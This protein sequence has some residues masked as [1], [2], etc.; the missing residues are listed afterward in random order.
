VTADEWAVSTDAVGMLEFLGTAAHGRKGRL[1]ATAAV[2]R[3]W[4]LFPHPALRAGVETAERH[5]EGLASDKELREAAA[6]AWEVDTEPPDGESRWQAVRRDL[7]ETAAAASAEEARLLVWVPRWVI[8]AA[9]VDGAGPDDFHRPGVWT[10]GDDWDTR[11]DRLAAAVP[12]AAAARDR[13]RQALADLLR[14]IF[15]NPYPP[16]PF[17]PAWRSPD[18]LALARAADDG[19]TDRLPILADALMDVG[20][21]NAALLAHLRDPGPHARGCWALDLVLNKG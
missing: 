21:S 16:D 13:G 12:A 6:H 9:C 15:G 11:C 5:A 19:L 10:E 2:R 8:R 3:L 17:D 1:F 20:C 18:A 4:H 14:E 7:A